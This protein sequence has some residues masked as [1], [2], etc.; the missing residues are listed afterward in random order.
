MLNASVVG[1]E[2]DRIEGARFTVAASSLRGFLAYAASRRIATQD[3]LA[4]A[5]L[6]PTDL[7][8]P[9]ARVTQAANNLIVAE[10]ARRSGDVDFGLHFAECLDLDAFDVV[11]HLA[12]HSAT[13]GEAFARVCAFSRIL[14]DAGRV[15][16]EH[17]ADAVVLYPGCRG[18]L[19]EYP[20]HVAEFS[21]LGA[22]V[23]ARRVTNVAL[24]PRGVKFK[25]AAPPHLNEHHRLFG[26]TP[27]FAQEETS[28]SFDPAVLAL[29]IAGFK[30]GLASHLDAYARDVMS[31]LPDDA[32][33]EAQ[34]ERLVTSQLARGVPPIED[35]APQLAL[36]SRTLQRRLSER[37]TTFAEVVERARRR[38]AERYLEDERLSLAEIG[39][40]VGFSDP[41]NF[42]RAFR[43]WTGETPK[44]FR[45]RKRSLPPVG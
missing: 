34:V 45:A 2:T 38:L 8:G 19:H 35:I 36:S 13:L 31:R 33:I 21:T 6:D 4:A 20:R 39:F 5:G 22:L 37:G 30:P 24:V 44:T 10:L 28:I 18:L 42:H 12:A 27:T 9:E 7:E 23:L 32:H 11:G 40:L 17:Q 14:H 15:D 16:L 26:V 1:T 3:V 41:S 25:H 43:R 29:P